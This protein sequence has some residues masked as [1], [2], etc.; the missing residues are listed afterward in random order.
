MSR[1]LSFAYWLPALA[2]M[3]LLGSAMRPW[4]VLEAQTVPSVFIE[5]FRAHDS[6]SLRAAAALRAEM[7]HYVAGAV[8]VMTTGEIDT[9]R[10]VGEPDDFGGAWNWSLV[11]FSGRMYGVKAVIDITATRSPAGV[12]LHAFRLRPRRGDTTAV[13]LPVVTA[14]TLEQAVTSLAKQLAADTVLVGHRSAP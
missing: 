10:S 4:G 5:G 14:R 12:S 9:L 6:L 3:A 2:F 13:A 11:R 7:P 1:K 8:R